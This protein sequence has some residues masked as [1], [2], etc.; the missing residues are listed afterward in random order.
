MKFLAFLPLGFLSLVWH[1]FRVATYRPYFA[2]IS[3]TK[4]TVMG[5]IPFHYLCFTL[6]GLAIDPSFE[7]LTARF[8]LDLFAMFV[9]AFT[10]M[11]SDRSDSLFFSQVTVSSWMYLVRVLI[12]FFEIPLDPLLTSVMLT[13]EI[14][15]YVNNY[16]RFKAE[17]SHV[18]ANGYKASDHM[19]S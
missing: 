5:F 11:R 18:Q 1:T 19:Q 4:I 2:G 10:T 13:Y 17:P 12:E 15:L 8:T 16:K 14:S 9:M 6:A 3:D 7:S